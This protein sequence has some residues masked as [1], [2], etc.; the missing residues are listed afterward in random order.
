MKKNFRLNDV[1]VIILVFIFSRLVIL[2]LD[3]RM[4]IR[5]LYSYWQYLDV[6]TLK[7]HLL[8]GVW[9]DHAQ[10]PVFNLFL[11]GML[12]V[13]GESAMAFEIVFKVISLGNGLLLYAFIRKIT[14]IPKLPL[15]ITL[16]YLLSPATCIFESELFYTS[17]VSLLL[18]IAVSF[19]YRFHENSSLANLSG[20]FL[21]MVL[22]C[23]MRSVY[24]ILWLLAMASVL[25]IYYRRKGFARMLPVALL[26]LLFV[27]AWYT[28]NKLVFGKFT[29]STWMGMNLARNVFHDQEVTDSSR[30][31]A[32]GTFSR[33][34]DY[35]KFTDPEYEEK[36]RGLNDRDLLQ[37]FKNDSFV[38][39][40]NVNYIPVAGL[41]EKA[42]IAH[43][44]ADPG[45]YLRNVV[46]SAILFFAPATTYSLAEKQAVKIKYFDIV[47]SF[48]L[49]HF[50]HSKQA[51][52]VALILSAIPKLLIYL[53]VFWIIARKSLRKKNISS[54][55][56]FILLSLGFVFVVSSFL[57]HYENMRFRFETEPVFLI[58]A[59]QAID[60]VCRVNPFRKQ[61]PASGRLPG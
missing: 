59:A 1:S 54:W 16:L 26:G 46:Q 48:N 3:I 55:N 61:M 18:L 44:R 19:I 24:H 7:H 27:G 37:E 39:E 43:I 40:N 57:E 42:A 13:F 51:R 29:L 8:A 38:N 49:V 47:Y 20:I 36:Y 34:S 33:I 28:K 22:L 52:R 11:G 50:A 14:R 17:F 4:S 10:P 53:L 60:L 2:L 15:L 41:F 31:E 25:L 45:A 32:F 9:F 21:P 12:K 58:L 35:K 56:L 30:I 6:E 23:L 5:P